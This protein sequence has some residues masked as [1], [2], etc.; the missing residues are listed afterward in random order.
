MRSAQTI[1]HNTEQKSQKA[2]SALEKHALSNGN[3]SAQALPGVAITEQA[4]SARSQDQ[5]DASR[6][7]AQQDAGAASSMPQ[8]SAPAPYAQGVQQDN[9]RVQ[10]ELKQNLSSTSG[11]H[12]S[13]AQGQCP[14]GQPGVP[15]TPPVSAAAQPGLAGQPGQATVTPAPHLGTARPEQL[16]ASALTVQRPGS[17]T[18]VSPVTSTAAA[19]PQQWLGSSPAGTVRPAPQQGECFLIKHLQCDALG[20]LTF[21][22]AINDI[23]LDRSLSK[24]L[25]A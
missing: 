25:I 13:V 3:L 5:S 23:L 15:G 7:A 20:I 4:V 16:P 24:L 14:P 1:P 8:V 10:G 9:G 22:Q 6:A 19:V 17:L 2:D 18:K 21:Y 12:A 11:A